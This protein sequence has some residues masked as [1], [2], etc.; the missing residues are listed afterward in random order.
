[1]KYLNKYSILIK[2]LIL[3]VLVVSCGPGP[4]FDET[5][6]QLYHSSIKISK[7]LYPFFYSPY[8]LNSNFS[9][10]DLE[11]YYLPYENIEE[12]NIYAGGGFDLQV[13]Y[14]FIYNTPTE[15]LLDA[16]NF[17]NVKNP[18]AK[19]LLLN[20]NENAVRYLGFAKNVEKELNNWVRWDQVFDVPQINKLIERAKKIILVT[21][22]IF[23]KQRYAYQI[24]VMYRYLND[25]AEAI[26]FYN[27]QFQNISP[28]DESIIKYW[29]LS[30]VA[31]CKT[32][33]SDSPKEAQKDF[34]TV[35]YNVDLKKKYIFQ[36]ID[37]NFIQ[38]FFDELDEQ[39]K[40]AYLVLEQLKN[41]GKSLKYLP[42]ISDID[43]ENQLFILLM[44]REVN[45]IDDWILSQA[46]FDFYYS[47]NSSIK[48]D[49]IYLIKFTEYTKKIMQNSSNDKKQM[50][51]L[52]L[53]H[54]YYLQNDEL[55]AENF[56]NQI[57]T[58]LLD[59]TETKL[60]F[61]IDRLLISSIK[62]DQYN[63]NMAEALYTDLNFIL[64]DTLYDF[65]QSKLLQSV[66]KSL[67]N[68]F[69]SIGNHEIAAVV[70]A[71]VESS[72]FGYSYSWWSINSPKL[73]LDKYANFTQVKQFM[74]IVSVTGT[75]N[76]EKLLLKNYK[77]E[78]NDNEFYDLLGTIKLREGD[79]Q[80]ALEN[81]KKVNLN[82]YDDYP[83][84]SFLGTDPYKNKFVT[85]YYDMIDEKYNQKAYFVQTLIDK[86]NQYNITT[87]VEK[88]NIAL[89][90]A[91]AYFNMSY[92]GQ[93]WLYDCYG[94]SVY[95][96]N[97]YYSEFNTEVNQ[98]YKTCSTAF[99]YYDAAINLF[100]KKRDKALAYY[101]AASVYTKVYS[102]DP[103][104]YW[105]YSYNRYNNKENTYFN[106]FKSKI[107]K[108]F[109]F[110][111][112][113]CAF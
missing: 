59:D 31:Y 112:G 109:D 24:I 108:F 5:R 113:S 68:R 54:L 75:N 80:S 110:Y 43:A 65:S 72:Y 64:S 10:F 18:F 6:I 27:E 15:K 103:D 58:N 7:S 81:Y 88:A 45:K 70:M 9:E 56:I 1:M 22:D 44:N 42:K 40:Y 105:Y 74:D 37:L 38:A 61:H 94:W 47:N 30:H 19:K 95:G 51:K 86:T 76:F 8:I 82:F 33:T 53:A 35:F 90:L 57:D 106:T 87:G 3:W 46:Y 99:E 62:Y 60:Q 96:E 93:N 52:M 84:S 79:L 78:Y 83:Y 21:D 28:N 101:L 49:S 107:P 102:Y 92:F 26:D 55:N 4:Y 36:V 73:F 85:N 67:Y 63:S 17:D 25:Y 41:P 48:D 91:N 32:K 100:R 66:F 50:W 89:E 13:I 11:S 39:Q 69:L 16:D 14:D 71:F 97:L 12:W 111:F 104:N 20:N 34:L 98:N 77:N 2:A 29:A 23:L